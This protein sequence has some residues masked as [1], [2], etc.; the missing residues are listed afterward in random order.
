MFKKELID[1]F[2]L[3]DN[4]NK[5][6]NENW[7]KERTKEDFTRAIWL[8]CAE[9]VDSLPWKWWKKQEADMDNVKI[10]VVDIWHFIL[11]YILLDFDNIEEIVETEYIKHFQKGYDEDFQNLDIKG[12]Y[13]NHYLGETDNNKKIIFLAER[14]AEG[15][16]KDNPY[17]GLFFFGLLVKNSLSFKE[18]YLLYIGKN[19]LNHIRQETGYKDGNYQKMINGIEDNKYLFDIVKQVENKED[20][21]KKIRDTFESLAKS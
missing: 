8:E 13:I 16:L 9:L 2:S 4:L 6:I 20:L 12:E 19:I 21:E 17:E 5:K 7:K 11:S 10:E 18:L 15:F 3:Q 1:M 14:V